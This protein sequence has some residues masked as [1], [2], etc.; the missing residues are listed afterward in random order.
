MSDR[1]GR[2]LRAS[3]FLINSG[4]VFI[5]FTTSL[6]NLTWAALQIAMLEDIFHRKRTQTTEK[7]K[8][9]PE[10]QKT[11]D[12]QSHPPVSA[13]PLAKSQSESAVQGG[14]EIEETILDVFGAQRS[15]SPPNHSVTADVLADEAYSP[16]STF[17]TNTLLQRA[18]TSLQQED[19]SP[20]TRTPPTAYSHQLF[21]SSPAPPKPSPLQ[22][23]VQ[24]PRQAPQPTPPNTH[25]GPRSAD[26]RQSFGFS[27]A[28]QSSSLQTDQTTHYAPQPISDV[29]PS[30]PTHVDRSSPPVAISE[31]ATK[32]LAEVRAQSSN[33]P[34]TERRNL[35]VPPKKDSGQSIPV[36]ESAASTVKQIRGGNPTT[37]GG[38]HRSR[39]ALASFHIML[40][41]VNDTKRFPG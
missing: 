4:F 21:D 32:S 20:D 7:P 9:K 5:V 41:L 30:K 23:T 34:P 1:A 12:I 13:P 6:V 35:P 15:S 28:P 18:T 38:D 25:P 19:T 16:V 17:S 29:Q 27:P 39:Q 14:T 8:H 10:R 36:T 26:N 37:F 22:K 24:T 2:R 33:S 31:S 3:V 11:H 40:S